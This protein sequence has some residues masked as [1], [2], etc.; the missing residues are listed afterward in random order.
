MLLRAKEFEKI[1]REKI[2]SLNYRK[3]SETRSV[4]DVDLHDI[5][6]CFFWGGDGGMGLIYCWVHKFMLEK[7]NKTERERD[8]YRC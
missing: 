8:V 5:I 4:D 1:E 3:Y 7:A 6:F 2:E